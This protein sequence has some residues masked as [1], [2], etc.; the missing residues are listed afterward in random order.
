MA[1]SPLGAMRSLYCDCEIVLAPCDPG[2]AWASDGAPET[3]AETS[4]RILGHR[5]ILAQAA[6]FAMLFAR[7]DPD[8]VDMGHIDGERT[9]RAVYVV[10]MPFSSDVVAFLVDRLYAIPSLTPCCDPVAGV[11]AALFL[12]MPGT[13]AQDIMIDALRMLAGDLSSASP[14]PR[15]CGVAHTHVPDQSPKVSRLAH[16]VAHMIAADIP[17]NV[18]AALAARF[19]CLIPSA[20]LECLNGW[21]SGG[22]HYRCQVQPPGL[23]TIDTTN[24]DE[25][26]VRWR[27]LDLSTDATGMS[28]DRVEYDGLVFAVGLVFCSTA[29]GTDDIGISFSCAPMAERLGLWAPG[30]DRPAG[31]IDTTPRAVRVC[32]RLYHPLRGIFETKIL[33]SWSSAA[34]D[35]DLH[36]QRRRSYA[37]GAGDSGPP[38]GAILVP[39]GVDR[40]ARGAGR[41]AER[42]ARTATLFIEADPR[43]RCLWACEVDVA[44][45]DLPLVAAGT[46]VP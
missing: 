35:V 29:D 42:V 1:A 25:D 46:T 13:C 44:I 20:S 26:G 27:Q 30:D 5:A 34:T 17:P 21:P 22:R 11:G 4:T 8:R 15:R 18:R 6:Y 3:F 2:G 7:A 31:M 38:K 32:A 19:A 12:G 45:Q 37:A 33:S 40:T 10:H 24:K 36:R 41:P 28:V 43:D 23:G 39:N 9:L 16:F 14:S